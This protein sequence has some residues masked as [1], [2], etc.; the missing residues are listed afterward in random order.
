[1]QPMVPNWV[2]PPVTPSTPRVRGTFLSVL[3]ALSMAGNVLGGVFWVI[4]AALTQRTVGDGLTDT[5]A[6]AAHLHTQMLFYALMCLANVACLVGVWTWKKWGI[7]GYVGFSMLGIMI[8]LSF[9]AVTMITTFVW[10]AFL[11]VLIAPRWS[12]F[13]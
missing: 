12:A 2:Q 6:A 3:L 13:E 11:A 7:Y 1:M 5:Q 8:S 4:T 10:L 9:S